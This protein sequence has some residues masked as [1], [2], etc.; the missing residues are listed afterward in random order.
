MQH[1]Q[2]NSC[3]SNSKMRQLFF[4]C[5]CRTYKPLATLFSYKERIAVQCINSACV[6]KN[7][8][9]C[10]NPHC[11]SKCPCIKNKYYSDTITSHNII[12]LPLEKEDA[13][14]DLQS[15]I[16]N[17]QFSENDSPRITSSDSTCKACKHNLFTTAHNFEVN[18]NFI[19]IELKIFS[20]SEKTT[21]K[22]ENVFIKDPNTHIKIDNTN[23]EYEIIGAVFHA[24]SSIENG[25]YISYYKIR[26]TWFE[27]N[28]ET[29]KISEWP[30]KPN[31]FTVFFL[32]LKKCSNP[33]NLPSNKTEKISINNNDKRNHIISI[34]S[35]DEISPDNELEKIRM[36]NDPIENDILKCYTY[37]TSASIFLVI[38]L[39]N[40]NSSYNIQSPTGCQYKPMR[41][42]PAPPNKNDI[43]ILF[44]PGAMPE[45]IGHWICI[46]YNQNDN[47]IAIYDSLYENK[48]L[49]KLHMQIL[50]VIYPHLNVTNKK[51]VFE[52]II[53]KQPDTISCG[54]F[55]S[56]YAVML[57]LNYNPTHILLN[58][59]PTNEN[60]S[61]ANSQVAN[62]VIMLSSFDFN[63]NAN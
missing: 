39:I 24:N 61:G 14:I 25:H 13:V 8:A 53:Q 18:S 11:D 36:K 52:R 30:K 16:R 5:L 48:N 17:I 28:D 2:Q 59:N 51:L 23:N 43:Q 46:F 45:D 58:G 50:K 56:A 63:F 55:A 12:Y 21:S 27:F 29:F 20:V 1:Y 60:D 35:E 40:T 42:V 22:N 4:E 3:Q 62:M 54:I 10:E 44:K 26:S 47:M 37:L 32:I 7:I 6:R 9:E 41:Y 15:K 19:A 34:S 38:K 57:A 31:Q 49:C 33:F